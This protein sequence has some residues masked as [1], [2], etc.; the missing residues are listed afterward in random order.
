MCVVA[1]VDSDSLPVL[2]TRQGPGDNLFLSWIGNR[3]GILAISNVGQYF[4]EIRKNRAIM[5]LIL[6]YDQGGQLRKISA[7]QLAVSDDQVAQQKL[8]SNDSHILSLALASEARVLCSNDGKLRADFKDKDILPP[9]GRRQR[10]LYPFAGSRK[11]RREFLNR[12]RCADR[13]GN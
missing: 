12:Q 8:R 6:R 11:Q 1:I 9:M 13:Q 3:H 7:D 10:I 4:T 2:A 5:E